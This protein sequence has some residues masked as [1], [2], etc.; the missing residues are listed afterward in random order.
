[1]ECPED[2]RKNAKEK[3]EDYKTKGRILRT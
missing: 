3:V 1:M 2:L